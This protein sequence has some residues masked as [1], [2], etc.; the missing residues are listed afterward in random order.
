MGIHAPTPTKPPNLHRLRSSRNR[1]RK[2]WWVCLGDKTTPDLKASCYYSSVLVT[3]SKDTCYERSDAL[4]ALGH[5]LLELPEAL[6]DARPRFGFTDV[7]GR[8]WEGEAG[9]WMSWTWLSGSG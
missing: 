7:K 9:G 4:V 8:G 3:T 6:N 1:S 5:L 2:A